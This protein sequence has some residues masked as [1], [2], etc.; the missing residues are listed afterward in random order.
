VIWD[1]RLLQNLSK[2]SSVCF[3]TAGLDALHAELV[4]F[5]SL[6]RGER[7]LRTLSG[8]SGWSKSTRWKIAFSK[9]KN[10]E[11]WTEFE[12]WFKILSNYGIN[13]EGNMTPWLLII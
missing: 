7:I 3:D 10:R 12:I 8:E 4:G 13:V 5:L 11:K 2:Q 9:T 6:M 1:W